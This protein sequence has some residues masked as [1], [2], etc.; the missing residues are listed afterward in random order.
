MRNYDE[1]N[2]LAKEGLRAHEILIAE[3]SEPDYDMNRTILAELD[4]LG[5]DEYL[6]LEGSHC[7][8]YGFDETEWCGTIYTR[9]ELMKLANAD[10]NQRSIFWE[11][12]RTQL[13]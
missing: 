2:K 11:Q 9:E 7:S 13:G 8:C 3:T 1:A 12:V 6:L 5:Y 10:Y 4:S